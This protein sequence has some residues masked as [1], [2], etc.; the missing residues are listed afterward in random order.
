MKNAMNFGTPLR[1]GQLAAN[2]TGGERGGMYYDTT[3]VNFKI[4]EN[5]SWVDIVSNVT[6]ESEVAYLEG[7]IAS[8]PSKIEWQN[9]VMFFQED[10]PASPTN[11]DRYLVKGPAT[12]DWLTPTNLEN[13][14]VEWDSATS[15]WVATAPTLGMFVSVD[16]K[17]DIYYY[18]G[19]GGW[20]L[21][22]WENPT[23]GKGLSLNT[24]DGAPGI[25]SINVA[26]ATLDFASGAAGGLKVAT[27]GI[28]FAQ[29]DSSVMGSGIG[30]NPGL[31]KYYVDT[32]YVANTIAGYGLT[33]NLGV[34]DVNVAALAGKIAI[35]IDGTYLTGNG[36]DTALAVNVAALEIALAKN[37][38]INVDAT[39]L[40]G[41]G[42]DVALAVDTVAL[43]GNVAINTNSAYLIGDGT[44]ASQLAVNIAA[45][46]LALVKSLQDELDATQGAIGDFIDGNSTVIGFIG[47]NYLDAEGTITN[48]AIVLD[49]QLKIAS[50]LAENLVT[51]S[52]VDANDT[53]LGEF[54][55]A[56]YLTENTLTVKGALAELDAA[57]DNVAQSFAVVA[58]NGISGDGT[59]AT[60]LA[61]NLAANSGLFVDVAGLKIAENGITSSMILD[62]AIELV[63][64]SLDVLDYIAGSALFDNVTIGKNGSNQLYVL[65]N[66][67]TAMKLAAVLNTTD[68]ARDI[69][70]SGANGLLVSAD[71]GIVISS[72]A[73]LLSPNVKVS[74]TVDPTKFSETTYK[75][76]ISLASNTSDF[77]I[78]VLGFDQT[79]HASEII[80]YQLVD[81]VDSSKIRTGRIYVAASQGAAT[82]SDQFVET[83]SVGVSWNVGVSGNAVLV[84]YTTGDDDV[85]MHAQVIKF[86]VGPTVAPFMST[87]P[88]DGEEI[89]PAD[90]VEVIPAT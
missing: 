55:G 73:G 17:G 21:Q 16:D 50:D 29:I 42:A 80:E 90:V 3:D 78:S 53:V 71:K 13:Y 5:T 7:L 41:D 81:N 68:S 25:L 83:A 6:L 15:A 30:V 66:A 44:N 11:G 45:L 24:A 38:A 63:D 14:I 56:V 35:N 72:V 10:P 9:S 82:V 27:N 36:A 26:D 77:A 48:A 34:L 86:M 49:A 58:G 46:E 1:L 20:V 79:V 85:V 74:D 22:L 54:P 88:A 37:V 39:Y 89:I 52:G 51:L 62:G 65:D 40:D 61:I 19:T 31:G 43:G 33:A 12:G 70:I 69:E 75:H 76:G 2:P 60:P 8:T 57:I 64:L 67:I 23:W 84:K 87:I 4:Y 47:T 32:S 59:I 28:G 18:S